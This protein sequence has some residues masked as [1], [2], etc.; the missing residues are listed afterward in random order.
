M[1][2]VQQRATPVQENKERKIG[3]EVNM[4]KFSKSRRQRNTFTTAAK[5]NLSV[6]AN[7]EGDGYGRYV[8]TGSQVL[9][10]SSQ[11]DAARALVNPTVINLVS[12]IPLTNNKYSVLEYTDNIVDADKSDA[13]VICNEYFNE[14]F[15]SEAEQKIGADQSPTRTK[16]KMGLPNIHTPIT[17]GI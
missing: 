14:N 6:H 16:G 7:M 2:K 8:Y 10:S 12:S 9:T 1:D 11:S 3:S 4:E 5:S 13:D 17:T 15:P